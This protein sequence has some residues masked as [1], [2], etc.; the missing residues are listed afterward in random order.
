MFGFS[1][2]CAKSKYYDDSYAFVVDKMKDEM[3]SATIEEF[4]GL[5]SKCTNVLYSSGRF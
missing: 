5:K 3:E 2:C 4:V 1:N